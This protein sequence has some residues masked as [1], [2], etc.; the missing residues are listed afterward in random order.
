[1]LIQ[2]ST[3]KLHRRHVLKGVGVS[4]ALPVLDCMLPA[5]AAAVSPAVRRSVFIYLPNGVNTADYQIKQYGASYSLTR[6]LSPL[7][8][9]RDQITPISGLFHPNGLGHHHNCQKIWLTGGR[10]GDAE[11]NTVSVDQLMAMATAPQ[12][13]FPSLELSNQGASLAWSADGV[14]LPAH[15]SP[16]LAFKE[17]FE[18]PSGGVGGQRRKL[19]RDCSILDTV[20]DEARVLA[21]SMGS[22]D[23][24]RLDQY[25]TSVREVE[26][27]AKR[28]ATWL[29]TP[30]PE[31]EVKTAAKVNRDI[32]LQMLGDYLRTMYDLMVLAFQT[33]M[34]RVITFS[35]GEEGKGPAVPEIGVSQDRHSLSHHNGNPKLLADLT[36]SDL[37]NVEQF[38]YLLGRLTDVHDAN[39]PLLDSTMILFGSGM[40]YGHSHGNANLPIVLA[41][42]KAVGLKH[43]AHVDYNRVRAFNG[44]D[45]G[46]DLYFKPLNENA[47]LSNLL[48][49]M[50]Q[51]MGLETESFADSTGIV[52]EVIA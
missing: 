3:P 6:P 33:D 11:R 4:L 47:R 2:R 15:R 44:Y 18:V 12:T 49:T 9:Y 1:M 41:G 37:F 17:M 25:M 10:I 39:G 48:L 51:R 7:E 40:A 43:G 23:R 36:R 21:R 38:A 45:G 52:S 14:Q 5:R 8:R 34:T 13:R 42:G 27:R 29:D 31:I 32:S 26:I 46:K 16:A 35:T 19:K 24:I 28:A 30:R 22:D 20:L 50:A